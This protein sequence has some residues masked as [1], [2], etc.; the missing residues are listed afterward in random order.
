MQTTT[1]KNGR[2]PRGAAPRR[3]GLAHA[4]P[5]SAGA[6]RALPASHPGG[7]PAA[8][9]RPHSVP[10]ALAAKFGIT[11]ENLAARR[12][13][14]RLGDEERVLLSGMAGWAREHAAELATA[15][16]DWQFEFPATRTF[17]EGFAASQG[18]PLAKLRGHL[19]ASQAE[20]LLGCFTGGAD[21]YGL[22]YFERRL[23]VGVIHDR[24]NLPLKW[25]IGSY[26][27]WSRLVADRLRQE[28]DAEAAA[29]V[30]LALGKVFNFDIQAIG[31]AF[32]LTF[33]ESMGLAVEEVRTER[34]QDRT[35]QLLQVKQ[36]LSSLL[37]AAQAIASNDLRRETQLTPIAGRLGKAF[38][39]MTDNLAAFVG[40]V[41]Q[42]AQ[43]LASAAEE[44]N[45]VSQQMSA[46][47]EETAT[48]ADVVSKAAEQV[49]GS[50]STVATSSEEMSA[51]IKEIARNAAE[52]ARVALSAVS[53][54]DTTNRTVQKLGA[55]GAEIGKVVKVI[56]SIAAQTKLLAI[57][58]TIEAARAGDAGKGF[59]VVANEV[60]ELA[61][62]TARA[63]DEIGQ[64]IE[65]IQADTR[66]AVDAIEQI[67][68][69]IKKINEHQSTI[70]SAVEE[71]SATTNEI[72]RNVSEAATGSSE[73]ARNIS[74]VAE[75]A[76]HT[77]QGT[78]DT[79]KASAEL[80]RMAAELQRMISR[81]AV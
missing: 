14:L 76:R 35:E 8:V 36:S 79:Q 25:Y 18:M 71:Q 20:Y 57:N 33:L 74:G 46:S 1:R 56:T 26:S 52:A 77:S 3:N 40:T 68:A 44:L 29:R 15:F 32:L 12:A 9:A 51:S 59:A 34:G 63:T 50:V 58:A 80:T 73:I 23:Q 4:H 54:A 30:E 13:F 38:A 67:G 19:E 47:A 6:P 5:R 31:D 49:S 61:K 75:A 53:A 66:S 60:K 62:E 45:A 10:G 70:A 69:I 11:E 41:G 64:R 21:G 42:N 7:H 39:A 28:L 48:Q 17:F 55:S 24:I 37:T 43:V 2:A 16:Y 78:T 72:D 27:E 65:A 22:Q 81:F